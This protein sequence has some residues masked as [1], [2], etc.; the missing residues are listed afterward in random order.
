MDLQLKR[1]PK[2]AGRKS[3]EQPPKESKY[4]YTI[5]LWRSY[6]PYHSKNECSKELGYSRNTVTKWWNYVELRDH[7]RIVLKKFFDWRYDKRSKNIAKFSKECGVSEA[8]IT[9]VLEA[10]REIHKYFL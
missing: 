10:E 4:A 1:N 8:E 3:Q 7:H 2:G 6:K 9:A 5:A